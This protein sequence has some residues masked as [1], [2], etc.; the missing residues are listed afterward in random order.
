MD[1]MDYDTMSKGELN[2]EYDRLRM[3]GDALKATNE[4]M[5]MHRAYFGK[6]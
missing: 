6:K 5:A 1:V 4:G 3:A 2:N